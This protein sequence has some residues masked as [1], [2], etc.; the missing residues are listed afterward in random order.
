LSYTQLDNINDPCNGLLLYKPVEWAFD[1]AK[2]CVEIKDG[3][4]RFLL[5]DQSLKNMKLT[6]KAKNLQSNCNNHGNGLIPGEEKIQTTFGDL[7][8]R[9]LYFPPGSRMRPS[10]RLL[11]LHAH[12][13]WLE[14]CRSGSKIL[15]PI[16]NSSED[17]ALSGD[18]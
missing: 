12:A 17:D 1:R 5:L 2:L 16:Y 9:P 13:A 14:T 15:P 10:T 7:D 6:D 3:C 18:E 11:A 8:R 4:M